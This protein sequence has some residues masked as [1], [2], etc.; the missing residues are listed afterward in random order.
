MHSKIE[1]VG[2]IGK[3][4]DWL[5]A[6]VPSDSILSKLEGFKFIDI[7]IEDLYSIYENVLPKADGNFLESFSISL[8][9]I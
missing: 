9:T 6:S 3:P 2:I 8:L 4:S 1:R 7:P 5:I